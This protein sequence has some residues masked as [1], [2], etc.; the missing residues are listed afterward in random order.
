MHIWYN[1][2]MGYWINKA[3]WFLSNPLDVGV[4]LIAVG[5]WLSWHR[6]SSAFWARLGRWM[7]RAG[8]IIL[9]LLSL[10]ITGYVLGYGLERNYEERDPKDVPEGDVAL[11]L[12]GSWQRAWYAAELVKAKRAK[13]LITSGVGVDRLDAKLIRDLGVK[14]PAL[15]LDVDARNT[16]ENIKNA[17]RVFGEWYLPDGQ[18]LAASRLPR[19]L[20]VTTAVHMP[21]SMLLMRKYWPEAQ[22]IPAPTEFMV[23]R[24][25][26]K[27]ICW[28][29]FVPSLCAL[30]CNLAFYH[31]YLGYMAY[32]W[33]KR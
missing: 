27:G 29:S 2:P 15:I 3:V 14:E 8:A 22:A 16:E 10:P 26:S 32:R 9:L 1:S 33:L 28:D 23:K 12:A 24:K 25:D 13:W 30:E 17:R 31:E 7:C 11:D 20:V 4:V 21:R 5:I 19:V 6:P 18:P